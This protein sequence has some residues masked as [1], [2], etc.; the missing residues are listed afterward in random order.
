DSDAALG[1]GG[2]PSVGRS[3]EGGLR[4]LLPRRAD[5]HPTS[6]PELPRFVTG[7]H[8]NASPTPLFGIRAD[9]HRLADELR[10]LPPLHAHVERVHVHMEDHAGHGPRTA[11]SLISLVLFS[12]A[13]RW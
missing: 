13:R 5:R 6:D 10:I 4:G 2:T 11:W 9:D 7:R 8:H 12:R 1:A 3:R